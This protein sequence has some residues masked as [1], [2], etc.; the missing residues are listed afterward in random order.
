MDGVTI[1]NLQKAD[2]QN[3]FLETLD[4]LKNASDIDPARAEEIF[5]KMDASPDYTVIVAEAGG[6]IVGTVTL[7][8][9]QKFIHRGGR[10]GHVEDLAVMDGHQKNKI[11]SRLMT[12][13][14]EEAQERGCYKTIL[15]C[16]DH[17]I[18]FQSKMGFKMG[19]CN[20]R[21]DHV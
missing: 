4:T 8:I 9:D 17:I 5:E 15:N 12:R 20:M 18:P 14:L 13:L 2:L 6:R 3:G 19:V 10:V 11:G 7:F 21:H 16:P 1:R